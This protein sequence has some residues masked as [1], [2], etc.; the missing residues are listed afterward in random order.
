MSNKKGGGK[1][2]NQLQGSSKLKEFVGSGKKFDLSEVPTLRSMIQQ[3][4]LV[5]EELLMDN[6][7][8]K[9][10]VKTRD[11]C[12]NVA[13]LMLAQWH[14]SNAKFIPPVIMTEAGL[15]NKLVRLWNL[16]EDVAWG[17]KGVADKEKVISILDKLLDITS[18]QC[19]IYLCKDS[20]P[21]CEDSNGC[22]QGAHIVCTCAREHKIPVIDLPWLYHQRIKCGEV[23]AMRMSGVDKV[24]TQ[25][26]EKTEK[27]KRLQE[28]AELK[29]REKED[30]KKKELHELV[31]DGN[32]L[33]EQ[34]EAYFVHSNPIDSKEKD[35]VFNSENQEESRSLVKMLFSEKLK[36]PSLI[37]YA[38]SYIY[39]N[40]EMLANK[41][42]MN[43]ENTAK[44]SLRCG[45]SPGATAM[46]VSS[47]L[48]DLISE[49]HIP[50]EKSY[51]ICDVNKICRAREKV[52]K[53]S[54]A[55]SPYKI[56][57]LGYD[58][59]KDRVTRAMVTD[60]NGNRKQAN[61]TEEHISVSFEPEGQ[62]LTHFVPEDP[63]RGE[64]PAL[65]VAQKLHKI[66]V[67][68]DS[69][70]DIVVLAGDSTSMNTGWRNGV[71]AHFERLVGH[72]VVWSICLLHTNELP[73]RHL[74]TKLD[75][76]TSSDKGFSGDVCKN[77]SRVDDMEF[78]PNFKA[79]PELEELIEIPQNVVE[80]MSHDS[81][82]CYILAKAIK[83][84]HLPQNMQYMKCG[85]L[86][87]ARWTTGGERILFLWTR[88]RDFSEDNELVLEL[89][90][91]FVAGFYFK[92]FFDI[93]VKSTIVDGPYHILTILRLLRTQNH[94][95]KNVITPYIQS[96]AWFSHSEN[97]LLSLLAS[98]STDDRKFAVDKILQ[99]RGDNDMG[100]SSARPRRI[101]KLIF[102]AETLQDLI[103]WKTGEVFEPV[104]T[105]KMTKNEIRMLLD[106]PLDV[107][108]FKNHTQAT[109]R[110]VKLVT[111]AAAAVCGQ[112]ARDRYIKSRVGHRAEI[113][114]YKNKKDFMST[115]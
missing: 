24:E 68:H 73:L 95:V 70:Q 9:N 20:G 2:R 65:K 83:T 34:D 12:K 29:R 91:R 107:P 92:L 46:I 51:L 28:Q 96:E 113:K 13:K 109:E 42:F 69:E 85:T 97:V 39:P 108:P 35:F 56:Q 37:E 4:I 52:M 14:K 76:P 79:I 31:K 58:G 103:E 16:V 60:C 44:A 101:P 104:I 6:S 67:D 110:C 27:Y 88:I 5:K 77:L 98:A 61:I 111:E 53:S 7:L 86:N 64:K 50:K 40:G 75:G 71:H 90:V 78:D 26:Q 74:I 22:K 62:Y 19:K 82:Q 81:K 48:K 89:L 49:G 80:S 38:L 25:K 115:L 102:S 8:K 57:G 105:A 18:C 94:Q 72:S 32:A 30:L 114:S 3:G 10:Q 23:S 93:R 1:T 11:I 112:E 84:G 45:V 17:R 36:D 87:H 54:D 41:N 47:Y 100:D 59:R 43:I 63:E 66:V 55:D 15:I 33:L 99:L 106:V 21:L